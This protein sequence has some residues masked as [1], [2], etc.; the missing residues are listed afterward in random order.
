MHLVLTH[1]QADFDGIAASFAVH[2]LDR[3]AMPVLPHRLNRNVRGF[4]TLYGEELPFI[5]FDDLDRTKVEHIT[6]VD[7]QSLPSVKGA[8]E[9]TNIHVVDH[10]SADEKI[11]ADW[12]THLQK[13]GATTTILVEQL[14]ESAAEV[15]WVGAT[16]LLLGIYEDTGSLSYASTTAR[17]LMAAAWLLESGANLSIADDFLN[18]PLSKEQRALYER[19][20]ERAETHEFQGLS[21]VIACG[22]APGMVD[23]ISTL[24]HKLRD[25][26][27]PAGLFVLVEMENHVQ[28]VAR[29]TS[30]DI[31]VSRVAE[32][33][34]GGGHDRAAAALIRD[35]E[36]EGVR[37][38]LME[39]LPEI[40]EPPVTV[41]QIMSRGPQLLSPD[42]KVEAAADR[43]QRSGHEGYP[44]V[45]GRQVVGLLTRRAVDRAMSHGMG[46]RPVSRVMKAGE[47]V[48]T[49][50]D[51]IEL[52]QRQMIR[53]DWG[54]VP[55][56][57]E[58]TDEI[59]GIVTRT[60]LLRTLAEGSGKP[61]QV[62]LADQLEAALPPDRLALLKRIAEEA[63]RREVAL[64]IV[65]GFVRDLLLGNPSV[66]FDLVTEGDAIKL[67]KALAEHFGGSVSSHRRFGTAKWI[68]DLESEALQEMLQARSLSVDTLPGSIDFVTARNE[69]YQH[70]TALPTV[71]R[72]SIKLDLHRRD[73]T[74]NT[75][76]LR[77]DGPYYG[78]MLDH[79]G[80]GQDLKQGLIRV[81]HSLSF[82]DDPTRMLRAVRLE[83]RLGFEIESR[84]ME[85][86]QEAIPLLDRVSG[87][88]IW[89][90]ISLIFREDALFA[91]MERL[92]SLGLLQAIHPKLVWDTWLEERWQEA[93]RDDPAIN[94][95]IEEKA[96][97]E[98]LYYAL[99]LI[100]LPQ[101][102]AESAC[103]RLQI[104]GAQ[105][106]A[107]LDAIE[108][109]RLLP[110]MVP[111]ARPSQLV[112]IMEGQ[113]QKGL[114]AAWLASAD[115]PDVRAAI[116]RYLT[117]W[118]HVE[119]LADGT[120]LKELGLPPGPAYSRILE[121]L[122]K[123]WLN[124]EV[125]NQA[126]EEELLA[127]LV[128]AERTHG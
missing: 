66:D 94:E 58:E 122:R 95:L 19:L 105:R 56:A 88:R 18:H 81:L 27:D 107:I 25:V 62:N 79:W 70:P 92:D 106:D 33:F 8:S 22:R 21:V 85:L 5:E 75:L 76:A 69:F 71:E 61:E 74:I 52:L 31:D 93:R 47:L 23:E 57:D 13:V 59:I 24:A 35:R 15:D 97:L 32:A 91:I 77:L 89:S 43:M 2:L 49:P 11:E 28:M 39:R 55:V 42:T 111:G 29:S 53:H 51:S 4:L 6:L 26:Y 103:Q 3:Q 108:T 110:E 45:D 44:V 64:Y 115:Q 48:V 109:R 124:G 99:W 113:E 118:R 114:A 40:I 1:E 96:S 126:Q 54:Q 127:K 67:A 14:K 30:D 41:S 119:P 90:E 72:G 98:F 117:D 125:E 10:H 60:D 78:Q 38:E 37:Q 87:D 123:A 46:S 116:E 9:A 128:E 73:F 101:A 7:T 65:G 12:S 83:Q 121:A 36:L 34:G 104:P 80:G 68:L 120:R 102:Q 100:R 86:L 84:T 16:L 17:D 50:S 63:E 112:E 82:V 20:L